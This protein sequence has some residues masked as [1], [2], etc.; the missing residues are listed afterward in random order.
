MTDS[1]T[2]ASLSRALGPKYEVRRLIGSGGFAEVYEVWDKDLERRLAVKVLRPDVAWTSGMIERFQRETRAAARLEHPNILP[3]HFVGEG[4]G[5]VYYAMPFVDGS[6]LGELLKRSGALPPDRALA[7]I[8]PILDALDHAHKAGLIHRDIKPDNIMLDVARGRPLLVDFGIARRL[9]PQA[10]P[11]LTQ[12]GLVV[13]TPHYMS[14][15]QALGDPNLDRRS[16]IYSIGAVLFQMVTGSPPFDGD[17]SQQIV[18][19]HIAEPPPA[20]QEMNRKVPRELSDVIA[21]C[22]AK[23]PAD[24]YQSAAEVIAA[25]EHEKQPSAMR[26]RAT[27]AQAATEQMVS[28]ATKIRMERE[29]QREA[30]G[31]VITRTTRPRRLARIIL[32][33]AVPLLLLGA[34]GFW[35]LRPTLVFSNNLFAT[36]DLV[37]N[38]ES[39]RVKPREGVSVTVPWG[40]PLEVSWLLQQPLGVPF[41]D[42]IVVA[43][44]KG[45]IAVAATAW[46]RHGAYFAPL[47]TNE[48]GVTL[49]ITVNA[50]LAGSRRCN[51]TIPPGAFR[52]PIGYYPLFQN[53]TVRA[54]ANG[55]SAT[56]RDLGPQVSAANGTVGLQFRAGDL[57]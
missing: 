10:G 28:G 9:D 31:T 33:F 23:Q 24:R 19:K 21:R 22:L 6:S 4:E 30:H 42:T 35:F 47:I 7:I 14:P 27:A 18:G 38:G 41:G 40:R 16:D 26:S 54:E 44:P 1:A 53:S 56:F 36:V 46:P 3:I 52:L 12:T 11:G 39:R 13:G 57:R 32:A 48:T 17:S 51:C 45:R 34:A 55:R 29:A 8:I 49:T 5:L 37:I 20:A 50:G 25:L 15:E 2:L 43:R